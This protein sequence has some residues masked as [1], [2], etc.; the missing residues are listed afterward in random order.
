MTKLFAPKEYWSM[1]K[2]TIDKITGGCGPSGTGDMIVPDT[3]YGLSV[4]SACRIHDF[5]YY[6]G[7]NLEDKDRADRVFLN[8]MIRL[9]KNGSKFFI[10]RKLRLLRALTYYR[11]VK[12]FGGAAFWAGKNPTDEEGDV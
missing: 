8:N 4:K 5:M 1:P 7:E 6:F 10:L 9:I 11:A 2:K 3:I 12:Y